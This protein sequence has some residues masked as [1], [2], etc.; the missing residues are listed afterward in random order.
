MSPVE[1]YFEL[2]T[3]GEILKEEFIKPFGIN[4]NILAQK[5][6]VPA[7]RISEI[8]IDNAKIIG[9]Y[10]LL[11]LDIKVS[12]N[13]EEVRKEVKKLL[14]EAEKEIKSETNSN[15][16]EVLK[17]RRAKNISKKKESKKI[18]IKD[19]EDGLCPEEA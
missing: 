4:Q 17:K 8:I 3:V 6:N 13:P 12:E 10:I 7:G 11:A 1:K 9:V 19:T 18:D 5:I 15:A 2:P 14:D 16:A